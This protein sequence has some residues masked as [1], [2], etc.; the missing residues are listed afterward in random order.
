MWSRL[1]FSL[2]A[3]VRGGELGVGTRKLAVG[4]RAASAPCQKVKALAG[5]AISSGQMVQHQ[6]GIAVDDAAKRRHDGGQRCRS[7]ANSD[8]NSDQSGFQENSAHAR[9]PV[10]Q[11]N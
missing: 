2:Q 9:L 4:A 6:P 10:L 1:A 7:E 5:Q 8:A 11:A 3:P